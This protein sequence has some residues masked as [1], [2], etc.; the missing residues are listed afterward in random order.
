L[1]AGGVTMFDSAFLVVSV[2]TVESRF[3]TVV[4]VWLLLQLP[5]TEDTTISNKN[6]FMLFDFALKTILF[7]QL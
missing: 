2:V 1:L 3:S 7:Y 5:I 6:F 4:S